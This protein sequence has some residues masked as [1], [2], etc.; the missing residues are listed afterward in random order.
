MLGGQTLPVPCFTIVLISKVAKHFF[1][2]QL[3][4]V[5]KPKMRINVQKVY[6]VINLVFLLHVS[7]TVVAILSEV[8]Y[9]GWIYLDM[10]NVCEPVLRWEILSF[11]S[12]N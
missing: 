10:T 5:R 1:F 4:V 11:G 8:H 3:N 7:P 12:Y 2:C 9:K 6:N